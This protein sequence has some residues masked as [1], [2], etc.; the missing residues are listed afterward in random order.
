MLWKVKSKNG[1]KRKYKIRKEE[2][3]NRH[4]D[5]MVERRKEKKPEEREEWISCRRA[6]DGCIFQ[7][8]PIAE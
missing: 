2:E 6:S 5:K 4:L 3:T 8:F 7:T 1:E